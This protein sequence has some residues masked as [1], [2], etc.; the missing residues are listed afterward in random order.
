MTSR[1]TSLVLLAPLALTAAG[2]TSK[3]AGAAGR[4][5]AGLDIL[6]HAPKNGKVSAQLIGK[7]FWP[8]ERVQVTYKVTV[9][10]VFQH[11]YQFDTTTDRFGAFQTQ[12]RFNLGKPSYG[13]TLKVDAKGQRGDRATLKTWASGQV[14]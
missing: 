11:S 6:H 3:T 4:I 10:N 7:S 12:L 1:I 14:S 9:R 13:Y 2:L 8:R 5:P